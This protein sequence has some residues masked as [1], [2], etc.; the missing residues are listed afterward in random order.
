MFEIIKKLMNNL[1][2]I[3]EKLKCNF[4]CCNSNISIRVFERKKP[5]KKKKINQILK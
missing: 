2:N 5:L 4:S 1:F 3:I